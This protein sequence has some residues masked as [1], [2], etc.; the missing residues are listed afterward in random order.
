MRT[1]QDPKL[2]RMERASAYFEFI[3]NPE[4]LKNLSKEE[5]IEAENILKLYDKITPLNQ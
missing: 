3:K 1:Y 2:S 5:K 4:N